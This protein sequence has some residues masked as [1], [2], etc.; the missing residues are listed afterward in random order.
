MFTA[1]AAG[2]Q[3]LLTVDQTGKIGTFLPNPPA[4]MANPGSPS[5]SRHSPVLY[6]LA[7]DSRCPMFTNCLFRSGID[8]TAPELLHSPVSPYDVPGHAAASPDGSQVAYVE[9]NGTMIRVFDYATKTTLPWRV[10]G[11][12]PAWSPDGAHIAFVGGGGHLWLLDP[13]GT[14]QQLVTPLDHYYSEGAP[15]S[16][17]PDGKWLIAVQYPTFRLELVEV[18]TGNALPLGYTSNYVAADWK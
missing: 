15:V 13:D 7:Y 1:I 10:Y 2:N 14:N 8:G 3:A 11:D 9:V 17:S 5:P 6:F 12:Y 16:W 18:A 4:T